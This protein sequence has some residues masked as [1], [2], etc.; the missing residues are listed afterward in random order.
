MIAWLCGWRSLVRRDRL[1]LTGRRQ[2]KV[3]VHVGAVRHIAKFR[4]SAVVADHSVGE[5]REVM[6]GAIAIEPQSAPAI[7][8]IDNHQLAGE[9]L[10]RVGR[11]KLWRFRDGILGGLG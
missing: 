4:G 1:F 9:I 5:H 10:R 8:R 3:A 6:Q 11:W 7:D 2:V